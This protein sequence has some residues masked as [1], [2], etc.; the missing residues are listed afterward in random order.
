MQD[1]L[2]GLVA[3]FRWGMGLVGVAALLLGILSAASPR[4]SISLYQWIMERFNWRVSPI[5]DARELRNTRWLGV[6]LV[7]L[8]LFVFWALCA[9]VCVF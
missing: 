1:P 4:R 7:G 6:L 9:K 2:E 8:S 5:D 3:W